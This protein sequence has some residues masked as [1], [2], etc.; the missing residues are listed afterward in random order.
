[1]AMDAETKAAVLKKVGPTIGSAAAGFAVAAAAAV[2]TKLVGIN[3]KTS[4][5]AGDTGMHPTEN[6]T[7]ISKTEASAKDNEASVAK[8]GLK[9]KDGDL[10][11][12]QTDAKAMTTDAKAM[13]SGASAAQ[14]K[15]GALDVKTKGLV[16]S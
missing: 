15:A 12:A 4:T 6:E 5:M 8:D 10:S 2:I 13:D 14:P 16:M 3:M 9:V 7:S 11:A 1:M